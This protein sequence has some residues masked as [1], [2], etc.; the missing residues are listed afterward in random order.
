MWLYKPPLP[1]LLIQVANL[2]QIGPTDA[3]SSHG[4]E[5][6]TFLTL[7]CTMDHIEPSK[8]EVLPTTPYDLGQ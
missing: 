8:T 6:V 3:A 7:L 2:P 1:A 5:W 4:L